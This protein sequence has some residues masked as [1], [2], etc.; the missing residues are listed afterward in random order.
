MFLFHKYANVLKLAKTR[1]NDK[2]ISKFNY[3]GFFRYK[4]KCEKPNTITEHKVFRQMYIFII[5]CWFS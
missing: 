3:I 5:L 4:I 1:N 2:Q